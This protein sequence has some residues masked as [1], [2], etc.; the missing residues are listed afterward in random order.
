MTKGSPD[1]QVKF[2]AK[3]DGT[4]G[5]TIRKVKR[6]LADVATQVGSNITGGIIGGG[7]V[8][9]VMTILDKTL[10]MIQETAKLATMAR[11]LNMSADRARGIA[12][13]ATLMG[14]SKDSV[15]SGINTLDQRR[16]DA[17]AGDEAAIE[18]FKK[19]GLALQDIRDLNPEGLFYR[20]GNR[21]EGVFTAEKKMAS[22]NLFGAAS[23]ELSPIFAKNGGDQFRPNRRQMMLNGWTGWAGANLPWV[24]D[25]VVGVRGR[26]GNPYSDGL[27]TVSTVTIERE[28]TA[29]KLAIQN[30]DRS[31]DIVRSQLSLEQQLTS[32]LAERLKIERDIA[33]VRDPVRRE[34]MVARLLDL[35]ST[36]IGARNAQAGALSAPSSAAWARNLDD[37][38]R[39]GIFTGGSPSLFIDLA[40]QQLIEAKKHTDLLRSTPEDLAKR[41]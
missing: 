19:L 39:A 21:L 14:V 17:L 37:L 34:R 20:V 35:D 5:S 6:D 7:A 36:I 15:F 28:K 41:I 16:A 26:N 12:A 38:S 2:S 22:E 32:A 10:A 4:F 31:I 23:A 18:S 1:F 40:K 29:S 27:D 8:N 3:D 24:T 13:N 9:A 33:S 30:R 11:G 25:W